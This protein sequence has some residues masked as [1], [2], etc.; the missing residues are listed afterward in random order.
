MAEIRGEGDNHVL[1]GFLD[2]QGSSGT[3]AAGSEPFTGICV[4]GYIQVVQYQSEQ[5]LHQSR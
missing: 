3:L 5:Y 4:H 1:V 2:E